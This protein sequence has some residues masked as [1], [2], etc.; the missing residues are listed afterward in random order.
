MKL[1]H[2]SNLKI[3][4][5][6]LSKSHPNKDFGKAFY[7]SEDYSQAQEMAN[8]KSVIEGGAPIVNEFF[9]DHSLLDSSEL[10]YLRFQDYSEEWAN[11][12]F[13]NR[14]TSIQF[15]HE[16]DIVYGPIANDKVGRQIVNLR[17]G[18]IS[19]DEF[20]HRL[21]FMKGITFQYAFCTDK[22]VSLLKLSQDGA[23]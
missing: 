3:N 15:K 8:F 4:H 10:K 16:Y 17:E 23:E 1:Y 13:K 21:K 11:F 20:L 7:L 19:F 5:I 14:D 9:F 6:D 18:Y 22:A 2:G 12:V